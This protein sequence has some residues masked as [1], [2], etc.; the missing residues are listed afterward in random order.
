MNTDLTKNVATC[1]KVSKR[2]NFTIV[3]FTKELKCKVK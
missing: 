2:S 1:L 3:A